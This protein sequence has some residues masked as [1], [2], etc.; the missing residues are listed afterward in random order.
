MALSAWQ[1]VA[2][3][4]SGGDRNAK[5]AAQDGRRHAADGDVVALKVLADEWNERISSESFWRGR[6][7]GSAS[8]SGGALK[9][10]P[11]RLQGPPE[12]PSWFVAPAPGMWGQPG[13]PSS[14]QTAPHS[15]RSFGGLRTVCVRTCDGYFFPVSF[16]TSEGN[17]GRDQSTCS[18]A[19]PGARLFY[20]RAHGDDIDDMVDLSGQRY[21]KLANANLFRTQYVDSCKCKPHAW[22]EAAIERHR[23]YALE[24]RR[25]KGDRSVVAELDQLKTKRQVEQRIMRGNNKSSRSRRQLDEKASLQPV[26]RSAAATVASPA[27]RSDVSRG[28]GGSAN[29]ERYAS[30]AITTGSVGAA[31]TVT[32][33]ASLP[34]RASSA[35]APGL[36]AGALAAS[37]AHATG[38]QS[39]SQ[40]SPVSSLQAPTPSTPASAEMAAVATSPAASQ[41]EAG[42]APAPEA[43]AAA[44]ASDHNADMPAVAP[45]AKR[46]ASRKTSKVRHAQ[47][48]RPEGMMR[49]SGAQQSPALRRA[50][51]GARP[52]AQSGN[53][54]R[55]V[56]NF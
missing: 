21:S 55:Q 43:G 26:T 48:Q 31:R 18:N 6:R 53:W 39:S 36:V 49:L 10:A 42:S 52:A 38:P 1:L 3:V 37:Q 44:S 12:P 40:S 27:P 54:V 11:S 19:C 47:R 32:D 51:T 30:V 16:G 2:A 34:S 5:L 7:S 50:A 13:N 4:Q 20:S 14:Q 22:E 29:L 25:R 46:S 28:Q 35:L 45:P 33:V 17:L 41:T 15:S 56:F 8:G 23:I 24:D 9:S